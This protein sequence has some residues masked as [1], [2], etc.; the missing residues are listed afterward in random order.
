MTKSGSS[1]C[2]CFSSVG[3]SMCD[4]LPAVH[5]LTGCDITSKFG[6]K[7][8]A[9]KADP[10]KLLKGFG[11]GDATI[12]NVEFRNAEEYL[13]QVLSRGNHSI[14]TLDD[15]RYQMYHQRKTVTILDLPPTSHAAK[16]HILRAFYS[17]YIQMN[18]LE[19]V[20]LDPLQYGF[21]MQE[22]TLEPKAFH[23]PLP[24][25]MVI[26]CRCVKCAI[27]RCPCR[28]EGLPCCAF[29]KCQTNEEP[30][31]NPNGVV[32]VS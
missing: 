4:V 13:V 22:G 27:S 11:Q 20:S 17:A 23:R 8:A 5:A 24:D 21:Q 7:S 6:T 32:H 12:S 28:E 2:M 25:Y 31:R 9:L 29:C 19:N 26:D 3:Q 1:H 10:T 18:C 14:E 16:G 15:L 30:C